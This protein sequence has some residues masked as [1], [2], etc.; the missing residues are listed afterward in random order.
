MQFVQQLTVGVLHL[1][2]RD[3]QCLPQPLCKIQKEF[4]IVCYGQWRGHCHLIW[5]RR[6]DIGLRCGL[7]CESDF[8]LLSFLMRFWR[9]RLEESIS[10]SQW[11]TLNAWEAWCL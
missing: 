6:G 8:L 2:E 4:E 9:Q 7:I 11:V 1:L 3:L 10:D 5:E